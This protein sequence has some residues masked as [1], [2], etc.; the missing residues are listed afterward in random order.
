MT[1]LE[2]AVQYIGYTEYPPGTN[3]NMFGVWYGAN[4]VQW[5]M[6]FVQYCYDKAGSPLPYKTASCGWFLD[7][8]KQYHPECIVTD[9]QPNDIVIYQE[10]KHTGIVERTKGSMMWV[11]EGNT[12]ID[13]DDNGGA[14]MRRT[15]QISTAMAF[16]RPSLM[17]QKGDGKVIV[18]LNTIKQG[19][20]GQQVKALQRLLISLG[21]DLGKYGADGDCGSKT[22]TA[23]KLFQRDN[24]L[25]VDGVAGKATW[26]ALL[27]GE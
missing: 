22:I 6:Q 27:G 19:S 24:G 16:I 1:P 21:Y 12:S 25:V 8:Y 5:C 9:P 26:N 18:V 2:I 15:R 23:I 20:K 17:K 14:V 4:G 7:W 13:S 3:R 10:H 11:I